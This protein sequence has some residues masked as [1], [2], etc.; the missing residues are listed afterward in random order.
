MN[1]VNECPD[2]PDDWKGGVHDVAKVLG[3]STQTIRRAA[4]KV[5]EPGGIYWVPGKNGRKMFLGKEVK[6]YWRTF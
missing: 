2:I 3:L 1:L 6:R 5:G 4:N